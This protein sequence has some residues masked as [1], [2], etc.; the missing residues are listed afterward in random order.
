MPFFE[1]IIKKLTNFQV[2]NN[3]FENSNRLLYTQATETILIL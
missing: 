1:K 3:N 2:K